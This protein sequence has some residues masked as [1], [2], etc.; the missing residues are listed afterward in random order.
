[1]WRFTI[2]IEFAI[3]LFQR[4]RPLPWFLVGNACTAAAEADRSIDEFQILART[5]AGS[6]RSAR[7]SK[8][9]LISH[10]VTLSFPRTHDLP[11]CSSFLRPQFLCIRPSYLLFSKPYLRVSSPPPSHARDFVSFTAGF[12]SIDCFL[13]NR[14]PILCLC[15]DGIRARHPGMTHHTPNRFSK[16]VAGCHLHLL[17]PPAASQHREAPPPAHNARIYIGV[18]PVTSHT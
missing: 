9:T 10:I 14:A 2:A 15:F 16:L 8:W 7:P 4:S 13:Q 1:M 18:V 17:P 5:R 12:I 6:K 11:S 3:I